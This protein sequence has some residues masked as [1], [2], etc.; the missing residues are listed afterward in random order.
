MRRWSTLVLVGFALALLVAGLAEGE[1]TAG[2]GRVAGP[3][4]YAAGSLPPLP[5]DWPTTLQ[6]GVADDPG[7]ARA[8]QASGG[9]RFRYQYLAGGVNTGAGWQTWGSNGSF[10]SDYV[11]ESVGAGLI[12][13]FSYYMLLQ[14]K[15]G[16]GLAEDQADATNA[17]NVSTM[18]ALYNDLKLFFQRAHDDPNAVVVLQVEP[19]FWGYVEQAVSGDNAANYPMKVAATG[20]PELA[21]L[22]NDASGFARAVV[23]LRDTYG[24]NVLLAYQ[25]SV[26]G[27]GIDVAI[28]DPSDSQVDALGARAASFY[29][30]LNASFDLSF[31][32]FSDRDSGFKQAIQGY[33]PEAWWNADD[34]RRNVRFL[35][36]YVAGSSQR[37]AMWQIP[38]GNTRMRVMNNSWD[39]YQDNRVEWLLDD[40]TRA[41]L[42]DYLQAGVIGFLFGR[43]ADGA[44]CACDAANDGPPSPDPA[45]ING[46]DLA[47][48]SRDD[49]GGFFRQKA[50]DYLAAG[51]LPLSGQVPPTRTP[52][53]TLTA[54][55]VPAGAFSSSA[56]AQPASLAAGQSTTISV[57]VTSGSTRSALVDVEIY[58]PSGGQV[59]QQWFDNQT[60]TAGQARSFNLTWAVPIGTASGDYSIQV[61]VFGVNWNGQ[62]D[63]NDKAGLV[64]VG[65]PAATATPTATPG[66]SPSPS[67]TPTAPSTPTA[68]AT[69]TATATA[70]PASGALSLNG[71]SAYAEVAAA[72]E[73]NVTGNW[74]VETWFRD[75]KPGGYNHPVAYLVAKGDPASDA[76][77]PYFVSIDSGKLVAGERASRKTRFLRYDLVA[78]G[79]TAGVWHHLAVTMTASNRQLNFY[80]DGV[81]VL[82]G[83]LT[84]HSTVGNSRPLSLGRA[85]ASYW[86]GLLDDVR[87]WNTVR[88]ASEIAATYQNE[89]SSAPAGLVGNWKLNESAGS[90]AADSTV[91]AEAATLKGGAG[92]G[93]R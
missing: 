9:L 72:A 21:G 73:L 31:S 49:D 44:T 11:R 23:K 63:W 34:F 10:V 58:S 66:A 75:D 30:S 54:T 45:P 59:F 53:P 7:G 64:S 19:D 65:S 22:P 56:L 12:P 47:S 85:G 88:S 92:W 93:V 18:T 69:A 35:T 16:A 52:A 29:R 70:T 39:H 8:L 33:G 60:F 41:H 74:T 76:E 86:R 91:P 71:S 89:L 36:A 68:S 90:T 40:P 2:A 37:V 28:S 87:I 78:K 62:Y 14:S 46:N 84:A 13:V 15:P 27:T 82:Q 61:G 81:R 67:A 5:R 55:P 51:A 1:P 50:R 25:L 3:V 38:L 43:G 77:V 42:N 80:L 57:A 17:N 83:S 26:W 4:A 32:E 24:P 6:L 48:L 20:L 79:V